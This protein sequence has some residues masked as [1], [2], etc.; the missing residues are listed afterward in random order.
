MGLR[1]ERK[2]KELKLGFNLDKKEVEDKVNRALRKEP[3]YLL[4]LVEGREGV[5]R[6]KMD[7][8]IELMEIVVVLYIN[9]IIS[10]LQRDKLLEKIEKEF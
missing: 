1:K 10:G 4:G 6:G 3:A 9:N 8:K 7:K 5:L 2:E